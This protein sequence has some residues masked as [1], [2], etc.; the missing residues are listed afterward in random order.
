MPD[1]NSEH[2]LCC[3]FLVSI[4]KMRLGLFNLGFPTLTK[5]VFTI[6]LS[7]FLAGIIKRRLAMFNLGLST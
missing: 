2:G 5:N 6:E 4:I 7:L 1:L 3:S